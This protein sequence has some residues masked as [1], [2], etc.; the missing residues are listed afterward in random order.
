MRL[1]ITNKV[2]RYSARIILGS[3]VLALLYYV[4]RNAIEK[5]GILVVVG[6]TI[7]FAFAIF[8]FVKLL[9]KLLDWGFTSKY[10]D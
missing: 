7:F 2:K 4:L 6:G 1:K 10:E 9:F 3:A 8:G 5:D